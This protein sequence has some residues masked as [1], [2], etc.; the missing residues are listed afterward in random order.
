MSTYSE[1]N[2]RAGKTLY[3][4]SRHSGPRRRSALLIRVKHRNDRFCAGFRTPEYRAFLPDRIDLSNRF[5]APGD[6]G[7]QNSC[8]GWSV[9]YAA[10]AYYVN[11]VEGRDIGQPTNIRTYIYNSIMSASSTNDCG[12]GSK[13][14]DALNLLGRGAISISQFPY[15]EDSCRRPSNSLRAR[16]A[17]GT[18]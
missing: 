12:I 10:R 3:G 1:W 8:V 9:G 6:Q 17:T 5:L 14:S 4:W 15:T 13:I 11:K 18:T 16:F 2:T 7:R